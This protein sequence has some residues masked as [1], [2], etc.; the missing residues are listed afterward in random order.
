VVALLDGTLTPLPENATKDSL[1]GLEQSNISRP[2][3]DVE[4]DAPGRVADAEYEAALAPKRSQDELFQQKLAA[5]IDAT[6]YFSGGMRCSS[7]ISSRF[8]GL[9][10]KRSCS[11]P[12]L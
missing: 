4:Q 8:Q 6:R 9:K 7:K 2:S 3:K 11:G 12:R 5:V 10:A 1:S